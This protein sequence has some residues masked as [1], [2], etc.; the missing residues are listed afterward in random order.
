MNYFHLFY[1]LYLRGKIYMKRVILLLIAIT[2]SFML[3]SCSAS[4]NAASVIDNDIIVVKEE[5][6]LAAYTDYM[7]IAD[8]NTGVMYLVLIANKHLYSQV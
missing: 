7:V 8:K 6:K 3:L 2:I 1:F 5:T 4:V